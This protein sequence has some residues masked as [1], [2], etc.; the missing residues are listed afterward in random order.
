MIHVFCI[1][2]SAKEDDFYWFI[3]TKIMSS[4]NS[5]FGQV[6]VSNAEPVVTCSSPVR[7]SPKE[8]D[9]LPMVFA[10]P[11]PARFSPSTNEI[12]QRWSYADIIA[13]IVLIRNQAISLGPCKQR[14][15]KT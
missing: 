15:E 14:Q 9:V 2:V 3:F 12:L 6:P 1:I 8:E 11:E 7:C 10:D 5:R 4:S 13:V